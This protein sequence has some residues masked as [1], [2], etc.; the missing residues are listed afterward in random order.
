MNF[1]F[2]FIFFF[3][4]F[5][6]SSYALSFSVETYNTSGNPVYLQY[7]LQQVPATV[8]VVCSD[9]NPFSTYGGLEGWNQTSSS[10]VWNIPASYSE[11]IGQPFYWSSRSSTPTTV[12]FTV[13]YPDQS[14]LSQYGH[15]PNLCPKGCGVCLTC[16]PGHH[17][18]IYA[19]SVPFHLYACVNPDHQTQF[20]HSLS[21]C[22]KGC[23]V[24]LTCTP[25]HAVWNSQ[26][27][28]LVYGCETFPG[29]G[30]GSNDA[31]WSRENT[32]QAVGSVLQ[33]IGR[34]ETNIDQNLSQFG[35]DF[36]SFRTVF[37]IFTGKFF[38]FNNSVVDGILNS[39]SNQ[40]T[41]NQH[42]T[43]LNGKADISN[44]HLND[45]K[46]KADTANGHLN[47]LKGKADIANGHL[48]GLN[49]KAEITNQNVSDTRQFTE[50]IKNSLNPSNVTAPTMETPLDDI[51]PNTS[52]ISTLKNKL[53]PRY[54][55][56]SNPG[57]SQFPEWSFTLPLQSL[58]WRDFTIVFG[59]AAWSTVGGGIL[60][61]L[62]QFVRTLSQFVFYFIF[63]RCIILYLRQW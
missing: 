42:L 47:D 54:S 36:G 22:R 46:G 41:T 8:T 12:T 20:G 26:L 50:Q 59:G 21:S 29:S 55:F 17:S 35:R 28:R 60:L 11:V 4:F 27:E 32:L 34:T 31:P 45:L 5:C 30:G 3:S 33:A 49:Q 19:G 56:F 61:T 15:E 43:G 38:D 39:L 18:I 53:L 40:A 44:G 9:G 52:S 10:A 25:G 1:R 23:G 13:T 2:L 6:I 48:T 37:D 7:T 57:G 16:N 24:C 63:L 51:T 62:M 14:H 58:G